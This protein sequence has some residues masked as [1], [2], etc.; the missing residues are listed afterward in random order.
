MSGLLLAVSEGPLEATPL[1]ASWR[2]ALAVLVYLFLGQLFWLLWHDRRR[3]RTVMRATLR[4][5]AAPE[6]A[7]RSGLHLGAALVVGTPATLGRAPENTVV[8]PA[9]TVSLHHLRLVYRNGGWWVEDL[10]STNGTS[11]NGQPV[12][13][14]TRL[15]GGDVVECG[16]EVRLQLDV[17]RR[18][19]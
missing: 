7:L 5:L 12:V 19:P 6:E 1:W 4:L 3:S 8:M 17:P 2:A 15:T 11:V 16:P 18:A 14:I 13:G 10:G 9:E